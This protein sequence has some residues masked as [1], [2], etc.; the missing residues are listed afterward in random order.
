MADSLMMVP[1]MMHEDWATREMQVRIYIT[2]VEEGGTK[3][4][5][6]TSSTDA[7]A[8][9]RLSIYF[10]R[11]NDLP[12]AYV[13]EVL[14]QRALADEPGCGPGGCDGYFGEEI[15][16]RLHRMEDCLHLR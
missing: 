14:H 1:L 12:S 16:R 7:E 8:W 10:D 13:A 11:M 15:S 9:Q 2:A 3:P 6:F 5:V 4:E